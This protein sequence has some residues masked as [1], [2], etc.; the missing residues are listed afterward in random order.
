ML[1]LN[2]SGALRCQ[3]ILNGLPSTSSS[4]AMH[5]WLCG[6]ELWLS[7]KHKIVGFPE[8]LNIL[9]KGLVKKGL[10]FF[11]ILT[12]YNQGRKFEGL[13]YLF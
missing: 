5:K 11:L 3:F 12:D 13:F 6:L 2:L 8:W 4:A 9:T 1:V 10:I 7:K